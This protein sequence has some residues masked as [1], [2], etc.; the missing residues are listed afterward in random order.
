MFPDLRNNL[1][2]SGSSLYKYS[3]SYSTL[4]H[5]F[6]PR[7]LTTLVVNNAGYPTCLGSSDAGSTTPENS[8][9]STNVPQP[10]TILSHFNYHLQ[11]SKFHPFFAP[12]TSQNGILFSLSTSTPPDL[13]PHLPLPGHPPP[14]HQPPHSHE[15]PALR[16]PLGSRRPPNLVRQRAFPP[17]PDHHRR[18]KESVLRRPRSHRTSEVPLQSRYT[19]G[20]KPTST[21]GVRGDK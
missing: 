10:K 14:Y 11:P 21:V 4:K 3:I 6:A 12:L 15:L 7:I 20:G 19:S 5:S 13:P 16:L 1:K 17:R 8:P 9:G 2:S 18:R